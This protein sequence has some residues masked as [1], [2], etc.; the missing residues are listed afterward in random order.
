[1][2]ANLFIRELGTLNFDLAPRVLGTSEGAV[3]LG[4]ERKIK[5]RGNSILVMGI[6]KELDKSVYHSDS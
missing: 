4:V 5:C 2:E 6:K 3:L 1:M